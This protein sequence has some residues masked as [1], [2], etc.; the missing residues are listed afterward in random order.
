LKEQ[1]D[2]TN[3]IQSNHWLQ[4]RA[5][6]NKTDGLVLPYFLYFDGMNPDNAMGIGHSSK[7]ELFGGRFSKITVPSNRVLYRFEFHNDAI[8]CFWCGA[9]EVSSL[10]F[11]CFA[12][13]ASTALYLESPF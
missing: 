5:K 8:K 11:S 1:T 10:T 6:L 13:Y 4:K 3:Y 12:K 2:I 9:D 7:A